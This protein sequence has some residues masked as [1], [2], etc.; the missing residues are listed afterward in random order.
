MSFLQPRESSLLAYDN[1]KIPPFGFL[2]FYQFWILASRLDS[3]SRFAGMTVEKHH[4]TSQIQNVPFNQT[5]RWAQIL[6][7]KIPV[8][9]QGTYFVAPARKFARPGIAQIEMF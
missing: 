8:V 4:H 7:H 2:I 5:R 9:H 1:S 6:I 3:G